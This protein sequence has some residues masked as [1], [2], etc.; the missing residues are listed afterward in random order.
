MRIASDFKLG[1]QM[2]RHEK[3]ERVNEE[4]KFDKLSSKCW[5][6]FHFQIEEILTVL[7]LYEHQMTASGLLSGGQKKRLSI[8]LEL[9]S[10]PTVMFLDEPTT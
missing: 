2:K 4:G 5:D 9:I 6:E 1:D 8:A 3:E 7:G 10:N